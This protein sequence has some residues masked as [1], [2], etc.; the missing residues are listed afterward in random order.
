MNLLWGV[1]GYKIASTFDYT[2][3]KQI[4]K[5][6]LRILFKWSISLDDMILIVHSSLEQDTPGMIN[7]MEL[8]RFKNI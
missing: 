6:I 4:W 1:K 2:N 8:Y 5:E 7:G 3:I